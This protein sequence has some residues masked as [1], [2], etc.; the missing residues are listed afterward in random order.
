MK[1]GCFLSRP[2]KVGSCLFKVG[3]WHDQDNIFHIN[4]SSQYENLLALMFLEMYSNCKTRSYLFNNLSLK[5]QPTRAACKKSLP[6][7]SNILKRICTQIYS[8]KPAKLLKLLFQ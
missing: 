7:F 2:D 1:L 3:S 4:T 6:K 5:K 8:S